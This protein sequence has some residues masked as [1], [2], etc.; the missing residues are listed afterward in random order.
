MDLLGHAFAP[1]RPHVVGNG[2][3]E[4][5]EFPIAV[6]PR[7]RLP[8]YHT[9]A[10]FVPE[11]LFRRNLRRAAA[12][13]PAGVLRVPRRRPAR[14]G[15]RRRR[16]AHGAPPRACARRSRA[17]A[18]G[19]ATRCA[20]S[21]RPGAS[22]PIARHGGAVVA[23]TEAA[24]ETE[25]R[26]R[27]RGDRPQRGAVDRDARCVRCS[28]RSSRS[29]AREVVLVDSCSTDDTSSAP[30]RFPIRLVELRPDA[31][32]SPALGR[33]VGQQLTRSR[34]ILFVDGDTE[35]AAAWVR[36]ALAVPG[37]PPVAWRPSTAS[38]PSST[39]RGAQVVGGSPDC[40]G[41]GDVPA[42]VEGLGRQ[43]DLPAERCSR[44]RLV[45]SLHRLLRGGRARGAAP[46]G[47][48]GRRAAAG[49]DG[50]P[51]HRRCAAA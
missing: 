27:G 42:A 15:R 45:Q 34:Y 51:S 12:L 49:R 23:L 17:S 38:C 18:R 28:R 46:Q 1:M 37:A 50:H 10:Y 47:G 20:P 24:P 19:C 16:P 25:P 33:L 14:P 11:R 9:L 21:P 39:T 36:E 8:V 44:G 13:G 41:A 6:T 5:V 43:R 7:L 2:A 48:I 32:L 35:I 26:A 30:P 40:F 29:P 3:G 31:P 22:P 4:L